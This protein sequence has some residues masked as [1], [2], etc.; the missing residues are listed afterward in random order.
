[1]SWPKEADVVL[2]AVIGAVIDWD[3][4]HG[5]RHVLSLCKAERGRARG[6]RQRPAP[7]AAAGA[8]EH[9]GHHAQGRRGAGPAGANPQPVAAHVALRDVRRRP[10]R[11]GRAAACHGGKIEKLLGLVSH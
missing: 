3:H 6:R 9:A 8:L 11:R 1:M 7:S 4:L 2:S 5:A 10:R